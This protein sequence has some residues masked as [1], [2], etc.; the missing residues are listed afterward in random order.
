MSNKKLYEF[1][2]DEK[3]QVREDIIDHGS[4]GRAAR[5]HG[6]TVRVIDLIVGGQ[7]L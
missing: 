3:K 4:Y 7:R 5:E 1:T 6:T 2:P